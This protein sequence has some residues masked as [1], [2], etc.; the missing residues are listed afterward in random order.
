MKLDVRHCSC[1]CVREAIP[2]YERTVRS[3]RV[4]SIEDD[5]ENGVRI[6]RGDEESLWQCKWLRMSCSSTSGVAYGLVTRSSMSRL[7]VTTPLSS[8]RP[9]LP[10]PERPPMPMSVESMETN[11]YCP[12]IAPQRP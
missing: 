12:P 8:G 4:R 7:R 11:P 10:R 6:L 5:V 1:L 9:D 3:I 2:V